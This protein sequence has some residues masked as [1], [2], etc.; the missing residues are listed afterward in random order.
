MAAETEELQIELDD[1]TAAIAEALAKE[2]GVSV[3]DLLQQLLSDAI[4][5]GYFD[6]AENVTTDDPLE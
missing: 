3:E 4:E 2:K 6:N 1:E 5:S